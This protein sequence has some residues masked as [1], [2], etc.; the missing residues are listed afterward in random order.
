MGPEIMNKTIITVKRR[1]ESEVEKEREKNKKNTLNKQ[2]TSMLSQYKHTKKCV[3]QREILC[4]YDTSRLAVHYGTRV[5]TT[6]TNTKKKKK[7]MEFLY[8]IK[9]KLQTL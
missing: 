4:E 3:R 6:K 2:N 5:E 7:E 8:M 9:F 1:E